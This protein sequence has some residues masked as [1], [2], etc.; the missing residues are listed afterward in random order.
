MTSLQL[1]DNVCH[2]AFRTRSCTADTASGTCTVIAIIWISSQY[3][4]IP[5]YQR[6]PPDQAR[7][8]LTGTHVYPDERDPF[9]ACSSGSDGRQHPGLDASYEYPITKVFVARPSIQN[10]WQTNL[11]AAWKL[12]LRSN[13]ANHPTWNLPAF[14][15]RIEGALYGRMTCP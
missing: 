7:S 2:R 12:T 13:N 1:Q 14:A 6:W 4:L 3:L 15:K 5:P 11:N 10:R 8:C 9:L